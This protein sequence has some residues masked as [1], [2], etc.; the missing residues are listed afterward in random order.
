V[1][2]WVSDRNVSRQTRLRRRLGGDLQIRCD[3]CQIRLTL[4]LGR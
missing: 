3:S 2:E 1:G 4:L